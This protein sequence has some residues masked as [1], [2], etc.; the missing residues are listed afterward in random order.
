MQNTSPYSLES[1]K[2]KKDKDVKKKEKKIKT[3]LVNSEKTEPETVTQTERRPFLD[4]PERPP[5]RTKGIHHPSWK[6]KR[7]ERNK[8]AMTVFKGVHTVLD[9]NDRKARRIEMREEP[10]EI[11]KLAWSL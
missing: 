10:M 7:E 9:K 3:A 6:A 5:I 2:P 4:P 11:S 1:Y 8:L